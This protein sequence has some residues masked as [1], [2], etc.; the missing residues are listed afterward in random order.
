MKHLKLY[1]VTILILIISIINPNSICSQD[2]HFSLFDWQANYI[3]P[4]LTGFL[5]ET[6]V[7][8]QYRDQGFRVSEYSYKSY[9]IFADSYMNREVRESDHLGVGGSLIVDQAGTGNINTMEA[10]VNLAYH[11]S[12]K[13]SSST[14]LSISPQV[15]FIQRELSSIDNLTFEEE[16]LGG[17]F[18]EQFYNSNSQYLDAGLGVALRHKFGTQID[19]T[20]G[21]SLHHLND[22]K[23][24]FSEL[25]VDKIPRRYHVHSSLTYPI[26]KLLKTE[27][28]IHFHKSDDFK[29]LIFKQNFSLKLSKKKV[30]AI[31]LGMAYRT[32]DAYIFNFGLS[33]SKLDIA[34][35]YAVNSSDLAQ[36]SS[37]T[38]AIELGLKYHLPFDTRKDPLDIPF[39]EVKQ[40]YLNKLPKR[41]TPEPI[42]IRATRKLILTDLVTSPST[43]ES[44]FNI[45]KLEHIYFNFDRAEVK[46]QYNIRLN[47]I[48]KML[49]L[50][51]EGEWS[52]I[53]HTDSRGSKEYNQL[54]SKRRLNSVIK[55]LEDNDIFI[56]KLKPIFK[57]ESELVNECKDYQY[58]SR[59]QHSLNRRVTLSVRVQ[60]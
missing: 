8:L 2:I 15:G 4:A 35:A 13:K 52:I 9:S 36:A 5:P 56:Q 22:A 11:L 21:Y 60:K 26:N 58:C 38:A 44:S 50:Y 16:L 27:S 19:F 24:D 31:D 33:Y 1:I 34:L 59:A 37:P 47:E 57:G 39:V 7:G 43:N 54:L 30:N 17:S 45:I 40:F 46:Q 28:Q 49:E 48:K 51:P 32:R 20:L 23:T 6:Q 25:N 10:L 42:F 41:E 3:N 18:T 14:Y 12:L 29:E 53:A 55:W